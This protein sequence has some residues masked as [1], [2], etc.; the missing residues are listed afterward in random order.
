VPCGPPREGEPYHLTRCA[1]RSPKPKRCAP[2]ADAGGGPTRAEL[3]R[4]GD[5]LCAP[6]PQKPGD[7][8]SLCAGIPT[9]LW[10][11]CASTRARD[12][13]MAGAPAPAGESPADSAACCGAE[14]AAGAHRQNHRAAPHDASA[15][16]VCR[17]GRWSAIRSPWRFPGRPLRKGLLQFSELIGIWAAASRTR[18]PRSWWQRVWTERYLAD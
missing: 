16:W 2:T 9:S 4:H 6:T 14:C 5:P 7:E 3:G 1:T 8:E 10:G 13:D 17:S 15:S 11:G 18:P 12:Q